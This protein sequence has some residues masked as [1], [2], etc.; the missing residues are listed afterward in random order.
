L[1]V[2][3]FYSVHDE[4]K[5]GCTG[6]TTA[7]AATSPSALTTQTFSGTVN[8]GGTTAQLSGT[9]NAGTYSVEVFE[10]GN[11]PFRRTTSHAPC[12]ASHP[13]TIQII[14]RLRL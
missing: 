13:G 1:S 4:R 10:V 8:V 6:S 9:L 5:E 7:T 3:C 12:M 2:G 14:V 11:E